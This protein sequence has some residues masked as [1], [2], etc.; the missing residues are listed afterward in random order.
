MSRATDQRIC[1]PQSDDFVKS[2]DDFCQNGLHWT[3][4]LA[5]MEAV[6]E[7]QGQEK[8]VGAEREAIGEC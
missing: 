7:E 2:A 3:A 4:G 8:V 6:E 1:L 5:A